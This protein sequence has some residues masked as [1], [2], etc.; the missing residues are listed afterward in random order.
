MDDSFA[1][2]FRT[3]YSGRVRGV[4]FGPSPSSMFGL[5]TQQ[6]QGVS[7]ESNKGGLSQSQMGERIQHLESDLQSER[8]KHRLVEIELEN[9]LD[10]ECEKRMA[11][12]GVIVTAFE[13][14]F[15]KVPEGIANL[16]STASKVNM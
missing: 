12:E 9:E 10:K 8:L 2:V 1:K 6:M 4:G 11:M 13:Q 15:G 14:Y 5:P 16:I 3:E 7:L